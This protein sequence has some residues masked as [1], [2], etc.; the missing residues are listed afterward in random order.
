MTSELSRVVVAPQPV[1]PA[2]SGVRGSTATTEGA[3][4]PLKRNGSSAEGEREA[5]DSWPRAGLDLPSVV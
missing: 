2:F 3:A 1:S 5:S 4:L